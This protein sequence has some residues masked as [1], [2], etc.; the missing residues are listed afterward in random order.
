MLRLLLLAACVLAFA[1]LASTAPTT[2]YVSPSGN[3]TWSGR[4]A[5]PNAA[6]TDGPLATIARARDAIRELKATGPLTGPVTVQLRTGKYFL[7]Q[8]ISFGP[9][10]TGTTAAPIAYVAYPGEKP[11][12]IGGRRLGGLQPGADGKWSVTLP[13][14]PASGKS[15]KSLFVDGKRMIRARVPDYDPADPYRKGFFYVD[16]NLRAFG[17][18]V[19]NIHNVGDWMEYDVEVPADGHYDFWAFYGAFNQPFGN[20]TMDNRT[21]LKVDGGAAV[22]LVDLGDTGTWAISRWGKTASLELARGKHVLHWENT[23]GGG[24][25]FDAFALCDDPGWKPTK[26]AFPDAAPGKHVVLIQ[27]ENFARYN[28][29]QLSVSIGG[30]GEKTAFYFAPGELKPEWAQVPGAEV[31]IFQSSLCRAFLEIASI[32]SVD[33][34]ARRVELSGKE[35]TAG[36]NAGDRYFVENVPGELT[37]PGEWYLDPT[38]GLLTLIPPPGFTATSEVMAPTVGRILEV[39]AGDK[40]GETVSNLTFAGLTIR[41]GDWSQDDG[42][43]GW[44]MGLNG[45]VYFKGAT[46][47]AVKSCSFFNIGKD[48]V[49]IEGSGGNA[50]LANDI[51]DSAEGGINI[52]GS[53]DN[54]ISGNHIHH[55]GQVYKHNGGITLQNG[56]AR[57]HVS[58]NVVH[59]MT[60][61][62]I[63]MK[64][65]GHDNVVEFNRVLNTSLETNDTGAIEVTQHDRK[66]LSGS[67]IQYNIV[68]DSIGYS[69]IRDKPVFG[70]WGIY[71]DSFAGG[72]DVNHNI[73]YR[74]HN[75]GLMLQGGK[76]NKVTNNIFVDGQ[77]WQGIIANFSDNSRDETLERNI[78]AYRNPQAVAWVHGR[79]AP[80]VIAIDR[81]LYWAGGGE[82]RFEW[83]GKVTFADWQ[84]LGWDQNSVVADPLFVDA[85]HDDYR[86]RPDSPAFKLGFEAIDVSRIAPPCGCHIVPAAPVFFAPGGGK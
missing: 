35:C 13:D 41:G 63:T 9:P 53:N 75:G 71:L 7:D 55:C 33:T 49:C 64:V 65:A 80:E 69:S 28:G 81:N 72:Y 31:H 21:I 48:A 68:G 25:G 45:V 58:Q 73:V 79:L 46:G 24:L 39:S 32:K 83:A 19:G 59:D 66:D 26:D 23:K 51:T 30:G 67:K 47:C 29:K 60:R 70:A 18:C 76:G 20:T 27:A 78:I 43:A 77:V 22:P 36:L 56:A 4:L 82:V 54:E 3:D 5:T 11:E 2:L 42:C 37:A 85:A 12:I 6:A 10:D 17:I 61:Y 44:G 50:V 15:F 14:V 62:G 16:S 86:L 1:P 40:P 74:C 84:K 52:N 38:T 8:T 34:A 57:N